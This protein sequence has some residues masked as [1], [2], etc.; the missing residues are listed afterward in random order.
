M[1]VKIDNKISQKLYMKNKKYFKSRQRRDII[2]TEELFSLNSRKLR[3][4]SPKI[5]RLRKTK[6]PKITSKTP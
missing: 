5:S 2:N 4:K 6:S 1:E 3:R